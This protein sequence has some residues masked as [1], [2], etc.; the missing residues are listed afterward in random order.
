MMHKDSFLLYCEASNI[1]YMNSYHNME[2]LMKNVR[3]VAMF[4]FNGSR[5][6]YFDRISRLWDFTLDAHF[7]SRVPAWWIVPG[8]E[9]VHSSLSTHLYEEN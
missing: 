4:V 7:I 9:L 2:M 5:L 1:Q 6:W 3:G 8:Y